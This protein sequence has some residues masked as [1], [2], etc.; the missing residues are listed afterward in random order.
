MVVSNYAD[1]VK[2]GVK[3]EKAIVARATH[4]RRIY[5]DCYK[6]MCIWFRDYIKK[7]HKKYFFLDW[8][9]VTDGDFIHMLLCI[10]DG[11]LCPLKV[12]VN[13]SLHLSKNF[14]KILKKYLHFVKDCYIIHFVVSDTAK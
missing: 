11:L 8:Q 13:F 2:A 6:L 14:K 9:N 4:M 5:L 10:K 1:L 3:E 12:E 7:F